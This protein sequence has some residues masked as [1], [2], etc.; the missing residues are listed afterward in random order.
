VLGGQDGHDDVL[1]T[2]LQGE[3]ADDGTLGG[4]TV[5]GTKLS[6]A[7]MHVHQAPIYDRWIFSVGGRTATNASLGTIDLGSFD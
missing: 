7:R 3:L 1:D 2:I 5:L 6:T 4:F